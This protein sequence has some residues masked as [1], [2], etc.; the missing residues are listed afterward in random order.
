VN[1]NPRRGRERE[2]ADPHADQ[3]GDSGASV[4]KR[5]K[6]HAIALSGPCTGVGRGQHGFDL[7]SRQESN[8]RLL[9]ALHGY[10]QDGLCK[11]E[12]GRLLEGDILHERANGRKPCVTAANAVMPLLLQVFEEIEDEVRIEIRDGHV[13]G[14]FAQLVMG[15]GEQKPKAVTIGRYRSRAGVLML[16]QALSKELLQKH[17]KWLWR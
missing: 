8:H 14:S 12:S 13:A 11:R 2:I 15:K 3:L 17:W 6:H 10:R 16:H 1:T 9:E 5:R 4:V 7:L